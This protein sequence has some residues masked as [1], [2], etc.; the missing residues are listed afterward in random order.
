MI[1]L[2]FACSVSYLIFVTGTTGS[3]CVN[4]FCPVWNFPD[5]MQKNA[6]F[7]L[8]R[9]ICCNFWVFFVN[10]GCKILG[11]KNSASVKEITNMRYVVCWRGCEFAL[12]LRRI[13]QQQT[14]CPDTLQLHSINYLQKGSQKKLWVGYT[15]K[16]PASCVLMYL[17]NHS[18]E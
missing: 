15:H 17:L 10:F 1:G 18:G 7:K 16:Q 13:M 8:F 14:D 9:A 2:I 3:A 12:S 5:L 11:L 6:Y 4:K